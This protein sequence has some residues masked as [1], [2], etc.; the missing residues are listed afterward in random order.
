[1]RSA[2]VRHLDGKSAVARAVT[3]ELELSRLAVYDDGGSVLSRWPLDSLHSVDRWTVT[4]GPLRLGVRDEPGVRLI[5]EDQAFRQS[6]LSAAPNAGRPPKRPLPHA[7]KRLSIMGAAMAAAFT[8]L[9]V[10]A[11]WYAGPVTDLIPLSWERQFGE[12]VADLINANAGWGVCESEAGNA[13]LD[14]LSNRL[15]ASAGLS[16]VPTVTV[17]SLP[18]NN[19]FVVPGGYITLLSGLIEQSTSPDEVVGVVAHEFGHAI[20]RHSLKRLVRANARSVLLGAM[21][22]GS[23]LI[24][25]QIAEAGASLW[26]LQYSR[27]AEE[28]ADRIAVDILRRA[29]IT[30]AGLKRWFERLAEEEGSETGTDDQSTLA[31]NYFSTHPS[32]LAR[33]QGVPVYAGDQGLSD[34]EW[35][36]IRTI[37][38]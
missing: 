30:T 27:E 36:A 6:L 26:E 19:A 1:M 17:V 33:F 37:C 28:E 25:R 14:R 7:L 31:T 32:T 29:G 24:A 11:P 4:R 18:E 21:L 38:D 12:Q 15:A 13:A 10:A 8:A 5:V 9:F 23:T 3:A 2:T 16:Y 20:E 22:G 35:Q 34:S